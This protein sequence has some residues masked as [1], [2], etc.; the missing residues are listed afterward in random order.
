MLDTTVSAAEQAT[1]LQFW[2]TTTTFFQIGTIILIIVLIAVIAIKMYIKITKFRNEFNNA[3][4]SNKARKEALDYTTIKTTYAPKWMFTQNEK[5]A[6]YKLAEI[7]N[8]KEMH[9]FAKVR[10]FDLIEP[11]KTHK[12]YKTNLYRIQA[13]HVDFVITKSNLV[14]THIIELDDGSHDTPDRKERDKFVDAVLTSC[15]YKVLRTRE[16]QEEEISKFLS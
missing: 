14:A 4:A 8:K 5:R 13:K 10:L 11:N 16:I 15:G 9:L 6:Y 12:N 3:R 2:T 7:A 1:E